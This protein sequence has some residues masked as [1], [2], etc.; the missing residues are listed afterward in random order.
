MV[1]EFLP[2]RPQIEKALAR[3]P[4]GSRYGGI[5]MQRMSLRID[6]PPKLPT[7]SPSTLASYFT[8]VKEN[9]VGTP[10]AVIRMFAVEFGS[11]PRKHAEY[12]LKHSIKK[13]VRDQRHFLDSFISAFESVREA[14][15]KMLSRTASSRVDEEIYDDK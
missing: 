11:A 12:A 10:D 14:D 8:S 1:S 6:E 5:V 4:I 9:E 13:R 15:W 3:V 2:Q 7:V